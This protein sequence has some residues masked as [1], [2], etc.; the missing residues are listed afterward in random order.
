MYFTKA[1]VISDGIA[2]VSRYPD[3]DTPSIATSATLPSHSD[4]AVAKTTAPPTVP[5]VAATGLAAATADA[6]TGLLPAP[7]AVLNAKAAA[8]SSHFFRCAALP[9]FR[10]AALP[11]FRFFRA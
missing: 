1:M 9:S 2:P 6:T 3:T 5:A 10:C 7:A 8:A 11:S 4:L